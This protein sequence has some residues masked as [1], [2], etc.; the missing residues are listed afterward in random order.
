MHSINYHM[1]YENIVSIY[2]LESSTVYR[3]P[4]SHIGSVVH[5]N[6][7]FS[8]AWVRQCYRPIGNGFG[9]SDVG[10]VLC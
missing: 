5:N 6:I 10:D 9:G 8:F 3:L 1:V 2:T 4:M 7:S